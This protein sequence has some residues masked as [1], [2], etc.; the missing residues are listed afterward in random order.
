MQF[1]PIDNT[2]I[3]C[4]VVYLHQ[5]S[6]IL[7]QL[8]N[9]LMEDARL[10]QHSNHLRMTLSKVRSLLSRW[11]LDFLNG[12]QGSL[13]AT[14]A[15]VTEPAGLGCPDETPDELLADTLPL[16]RLLALTG[17]CD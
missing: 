13:R 2:R 14:W 16:S 6:D 4:T 11:P 10:A 5:H 17:F 15:V 9:R 12:F 1:L 8:Q 7:E 3:S